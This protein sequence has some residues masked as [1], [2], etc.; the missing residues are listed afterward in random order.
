[1]KPEKQI[2]LQIRSVENGYVVSE[3]NYGNT[4]IEGRRWVAETS[5]ALCALIAD[6]CRY[7]EDQS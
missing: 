2:N 4:M 7:E 5:F 1:M 3:V 6:L